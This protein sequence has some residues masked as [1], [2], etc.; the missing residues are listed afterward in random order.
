MSKK[1]MLERAIDNNLSSFNFDLQLFAPDPNDLLIGAG[2]VLFRRWENGEKTVF[3]HLGNCPEF[4]LAPNIE[5][6]TKYSSMDSAKEVYA[7]AIKSMGYTPSIT[8]DEYNPFNLALGLYGEQGIEVQK[9]K[10]VAK[11]EY[12]AV[13]G[14]L[15][16][17]PYKNITDVTVSP[18]TAT[19]AQVGA[20]TSFSQAGTAGTAK[21]TS[22]GNYIGTDSGAYYIE[23]TKANTVEGT[24]TDAEFTWRKGIAGTPSTETVVTGTSQSI[25]EGVTIQFAAGSSGQDL[26][27]GEIYEIKVKA[28]GGSYIAGVDYILDKSML[29]GGIIS[30]PTTSN[31]PDGAK[32][33]VS[34]TVPEAKY[35]KV[36]GGTVKKIEGDLMFIGDPKHG[37]PYVLEIWHVNLTPNGDVGL[38][39]EEWGSF[40]IEM[41]VLAD[42]VNHP[43]E[44]FF[45]M[46]DVA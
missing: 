23:I 27:V 7:E 16:S 26:V 34:C 37:R 8:L 11:A 35:P 10:T 44:P 22:G 39:T 24:I 21:V 20:V 40:T 17:V 32:V 42:R 46:T 12:T 13:K 14:A 18:I 38:I 9:A 36:M 19:P 1:Q 30:I 15:I 4:K 29:R 2:K 43:D 3:M 28:A 6:V 45:K 5:K 31:I 25:A 33:F 41:T